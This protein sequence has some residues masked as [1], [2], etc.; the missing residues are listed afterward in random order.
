MISSQSLA[1]TVRRRSIGA[2]PI[3]GVPREHEGGRPNSRWRRGLQHG[4]R[5]SLRLDECAGGKVGP[6][7]LKHGGDIRGITL[8]PRGGCGSRTSATTGCPGWPP[9]G[10]YAGS[11]GPARS[12]RR[13]GSGRWPGAAAHSAGGPGSPTS[14]SRPTGTPGSA[15]CTT[16]GSGTASS[17][18]T[19]AAATSPATATR[20]AS[21]ST[22]PATTALGDVEL[23]SGTS[24]VRSRR[25]AVWSDSPADLQRNG[26][27]GH[28]DGQAEPES[29]DEQTADDLHGYLPLALRTA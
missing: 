25:S 18:G 2:K 12:G 8:T 14:S 26:G 17:T 16:S 19:G 27:S 1:V 10:S 24:V 21:A 7:A 9:S 13:T 23:L 4:V 15:P 3:R 20:A 5:A 28:A 29:G 11:P 22:A 6:D